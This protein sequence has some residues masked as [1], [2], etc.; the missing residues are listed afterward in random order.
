LAAVN[1]ASYTNS[2]LPNGK[3]AQGAL[4]IA[5]G[6][7]MGPASIERASTF[8]LP[9]SLAGTSVRVTVN[10]VTA[11]CIM[12]YAVSGQ[13]AAILPSDVPVGTGT[14]V[15][16]YNG[17]MSAPLSITVVEHSFGIFAINQGGSGPGVFL[18]AF[19]N[20]AN[21]LETA[22]NPN[23]QWD[24]WGTGLG[25]VNGN[26]AEE[27]L[28]G[29]IASA[30]VRVFFG[31]VEAQ[32][33]Y[34]GRSGCC[35]GVDQVRVVVPPQ[36]AGCYVPV[37]VVVNGVISNFVS[38]S[39]ADSGSTCSDPLGYDP[40]TYQQLLTSGKLRLGSIGLSRFYVETKAFGYQGDAATAN[41]STFGSGSLGLGQVPQAGA[42]V[43]VQFPTPTVPTPLGLD[44]GAQIPMTSPMGNYNLVP[45]AFG[46]YVGQY[47]IAFSPGTTGVPGIVGDGT[48][49]MPTRMG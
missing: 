44:A 24:I 37:Y 18:D 45:P 19:T 36:V 35:A 42:C 49:L 11:D 5:F 3:L 8:P 15:L 27:P 14:M 29:D 26:E 4:F 43:V 1:G 6:E 33:L 39:V 12:L 32:V 25:A 34:R 48:G 20:V 13:V 9:T 17:V 7:G 46:S 2:S 41:F 10:S 47:G 31:A 21:G 23:G 30:D 22:A 38:M 16:T 28:P 40:E